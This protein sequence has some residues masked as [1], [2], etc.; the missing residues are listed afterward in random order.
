MIPET[1]FFNPSRRKKLFALLVSPTLLRQAVLNSVEFNGQ[2]CGGTIEIECVNPDRMLPAEFE[3]GKS[4]RSQCEP[5]F[6]FLLGL[7]APESAGIGSG[8]HGEKRRR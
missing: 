3:S 5:Q 6:F 7:L 8:I 1:Q 4:S 2:L